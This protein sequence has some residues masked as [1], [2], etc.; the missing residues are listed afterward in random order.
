MS[1]G[2]EGE[3]EGSHVSAATYDS[4]VV[5]GQDD[6]YQ[7][8]GVHTLQ[9]AGG[10]EA[11]A[12]GANKTAGL[13]SEID[14]AA[15]RRE[16]DGEKVKTLLSIKALAQDQQLAGD[17]RKASSSYLGTGRSAGQRE[18]KDI[19]KL[20]NNL[21]QQAW[22]K[23]ATTGNAEPLIRARRDVEL[24]EAVQS[25][26]ALCVSSSRA[27]ALLWSSMP[28]KNA[29]RLGALDMMSQV[30]PESD[31]H[32]F[33]AIPVGQDLETL[34]RITYVEPVGHVSRVECYAGTE[35]APGSPMGLSHTI[36][37]KKVGDIHAET[38]VSPFLS[39][40]VHL[41]RDSEEFRKCRAMW[42]AASGIGSLGPTFGTSRSLFDIKEHGIQEA[43]MVPS[44]A[45]DVA[46]LTKCADF[47][48]VEEVAA[49]HGISQT[50]DGLN[51]VSP[52]HFGIKTFSSHA[53]FSAETPA[54]IRSPERAGRPVGFDMMIEQTHPQ[55]RSPR[56]HRRSLNLE[57]G[58]HIHDEIH[59]M[60]R[61]IASFRDVVPSTILDVTK[62]YQEFYPS[63]NSTTATA[64]AV[65]LPFIVSN[66]SLVAASN[67][68]LPSV[69]YVGDGIV[70]AEDDAG[71]PKAKATQDAPTL[72]SLTSLSPPVFTVSGTAVPC[73]AVSDRQM[74]SGRR[75]V[76][77][78]VRMGVRVGK[79]RKS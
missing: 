51:T 58:P 72:P 54:R 65:A 18:A 76:P 42:P 47:D 37:R 13:K 12:A 71:G 66:S 61:S 57:R 20:L 22:R 46:T 36:A 28:P 41:P 43:E 19:R 68:K 56:Q 67:S 4:L 60:A 59:R 6:T 48:S 32:H 77:V 55:Q 17:R 21:H 27:P 45:Y 78:G 8:Q 23:S 31:L 49:G 52:Q 35:G 16:L 63:H 30:L 44:D 74:V 38:Q 64:R 73:S 62:N 9:S 5:H 2:W 39:A 15:E 40:T 70:E 75:N 24:C 26:L 33:H 7:M 69:Y 25:D 50:V 79:P 10:G 11:P 29:R 14:R 3:H 34:K 1:Q 53:G